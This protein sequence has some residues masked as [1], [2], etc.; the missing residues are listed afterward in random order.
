MKKPQSL[1]ALGSCLSLSCRYSL[2]SV[3][4]PDYFLV[5]LDTFTSHPLKFVPTDLCPP[6]QISLQARVCS[7]WLFLLSKCH[8]RGSYFMGHTQMLTDRQMF[9]F[10]EWGVRGPGTQCLTLAR[11]APCIG[12]LHRCLQHCLPFRGQPVYFCLCSTLKRDTWRASDL[13]RIF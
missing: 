7:S 8:T 12:E 13:N 11:S 1:H 5:T 6:R 4:I 10:P 2:V 3:A 9:I